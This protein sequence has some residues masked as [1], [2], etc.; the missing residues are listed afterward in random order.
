[1]SALRQHRAG[2]REAGGA[3]GANAAQASAGHKFYRLTSSL[4]ADLG[5]GRSCSGLFSHFSLR[6][7]SLPFAHRRQVRGI[8]LPR[9]PAATHSRADLAIRQIHRIET[10]PSKHV[11]DPFHSFKRLSCVAGFADQQPRA[12]PFSSV[13]EVIASGATIV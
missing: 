9:G 12:R 8:L 2:Q 5:P 11:S 4:P 3:S 10:Q 13:Q 1:M 6:G 7:V